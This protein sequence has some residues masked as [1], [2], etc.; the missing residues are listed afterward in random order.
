MR[1]KVSNVRGRFI[2]IRCSPQSEAARAALM[3]L[4]TKELFYIALDGRLMLSRFVS[5]QRP[6]RHAYGTAANSTTNLPPGQRFLMNA[7]IEQVPS[8][9]TVILNWKAKP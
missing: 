2:L 4:S 8:P 1:S 9:I 5:L 6:V 3:M 7:I